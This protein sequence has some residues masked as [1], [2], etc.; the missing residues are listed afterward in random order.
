M[1]AYDSC[2]TTRSSLRYIWVLWKLIGLLSYLFVDW[3]QILLVVVHLLHAEILMTEVGKCANKGKHAD[4]ELE[5]S[6]DNPFSSTYN[7]LPS[8]MTNH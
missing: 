2:G 5:G 6:P 8:F 4:A 3:P 7:W 1:I